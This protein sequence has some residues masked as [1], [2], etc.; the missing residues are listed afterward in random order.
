MR[1]T[2]QSQQGGKQQEQQREKQ[3]EQQGE[4]QEEQQGTL[5]VTRVGEAG[6][7]KFPW[8]R[9]RMDPVF[10]VSQ[11]FKL[12]DCNEAA[13]RY[14][15]YRD[16]DEMLQRFDLMKLSPEFQPDGRRSI[17]VQ[18]ENHAR[19]LR[20]EVV[21]FEW[22]TLASDGEPFLVL[23]T[24]REIVIDGAKHLL[25]I[26][27]D[28]SEM[29][30][31]E[32]ELKAAKEAAEAANE[33]KNRFLAN[34][35]H[36][37]R[38]PMNGVIGVAEL[39]LRTPLTEEQSMYLDVICS[40]GNALMH[41]I[42]DVLDITKIE[43]H[44]LVVDAYPFD[45]HVTIEQALSAIRVAANSKQLGLHVSVCEQLPV[46]VIG[47]QFRV[48]QILLNLLSN[49]IKFTDRGEVEVQVYLQSKPHLPSALPP[50]EAPSAPSAPATHCSAATH[51]VAATHNLVGTHNPAAASLVEPH[52]EKGESN[53]TY[54]LEASSIEAHSV[55]AHSPDTQLLNNE[56]GPSKAEPGT[57]TGPPPPG[58]A[59][60][61]AAAACSEGAAGAE[62]ERAERAQV[63]AQEEAAVLAAAPHTPPLHPPLPG[64]IP[65]PP[66]KPF[67]VPHTPPLH[68]PLPGSSL[69]F[70]AAAA[71]IRT[72]HSATHLS[73]LA[74]GV[75]EG[76]YQ[77][78]ERVCEGKQGVVCEPTQKSCRAGEGGFKGLQT[79]V[80]Q[81]SVGKAPPAKRARVGGGAGKESGVRHARQA[82][83]N[84][85]G[86]VL[87]RADAAADAAVVAGGAVLTGLGGGTGVSE[88]EELG[89]GADRIVGGRM[90]YPEKAVRVGAREA[91]TREILTAAAAAAASAAIGE[92]SRAATQEAEGRE[93]VQV[94]TKQRD[95]QRQE[96]GG[97]PARAAA[98]GA[99]SLAG[100]AGGAAPLDR[101]GPE[102]NAL[103]CSQQ[104]PP[105]VQPASEETPGERGAVQEE[106]GEAG[107]A[108]VWV[109]I[110]VRDTGVGIPEDQLGR[111]FTPFRQVDDSSCRKHGGTGLGLSICRS[112]AALMGGCISVASSPRHGSTFSLS[113]PF[114][115]TSAPPACS[116]QEADLKVVGSASLPD[117]V[118]MPLM[119]A[120]DPLVQQQQRQKEERQ[121]QE[122]QRQE[123]EQE[124]EEEEEEEGDSAGI[125][126]GAG[127]G[128][129]AAAS[130]GGSGCQAGSG[131]SRDGGPFSG[132]RCLV[133]EDNAVNRM[134]VVQLLRNLR[135][136]C[137]VAENGH[138]A[139]EACRSTNYH[140]IFMDCQMPVM[141]GFEATTHIRRLQATPHT[142]ESGVVEEASPGEA[143]QAGRDAQGGCGG[144]VYTKTSQQQQSGSNAQQRSAIYALTASVL[145]HERDKCA[146]AGMDGFLAKP[147]RM[148]DLQLVL[149]EVLKG[150]M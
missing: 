128:G 84:A 25:S 46:M 63:E 108:A 17:D 143:V 112:L 120:D 51:T 15:K 86:A 92:A 101:P 34:M 14:M 70:P 38:T 44:S 131:G 82:S 147:I 145:K 68:P 39:L 2:V 133:V 57:T 102:Q 5:V 35:S 12:V 98:A 22:Q 97:D 21:I 11:E 66:P 121:R 78:G 64:L 31:K 135:V 53:S 52:S 29:K 129:A 79:G 32:E 148:R 94:G 50:V 7:V 77:A 130:A 69:S 134:V 74:E 114:T 103:H 43:T 26:W 99:C 116:G 90:I 136:S 8:R 37:L 95:M 115:P 122:Q 142:T 73:A 42:S 76:P 41:I 150:H 75:S 62:G 9:G 87:A 1:E 146:R 139:V 71:Q 88:G 45:L 16:R 85:P 132:L 33:A 4:K 18:M 3:E 140:V 24:V 93:D 91:G 23:V 27:H 89:G 49:A 55:E 6:K 65:E 110:D 138:K 141:D 54:A 83:W 61:A 19:M 28:M 30:R 47:D 125:S 124:E 118:A 126:G 56:S 60:A 105:Q 144:Q 100:S 36:E 109:R 48:R 58:A 80:Q 107:E 40:S 127:G 13:V 104:H 149:Q 20:G 137:D 113:L 106:P 72:C 67:A 123:A 117:V 59:T 111:L 119:P 96:E 10:T 81:G